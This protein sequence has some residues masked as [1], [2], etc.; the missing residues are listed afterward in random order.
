MRNIYILILMI[1]ASTSWGQPVFQNAMEKPGKDFSAPVQIGSLA[2]GPG[3]T[4]LNYTWNFSNMTFSGNSKF[5]VIDPLMSLYKNN[6]PQASYVYIVDSAYNYFIVT[7]SNLQMVTKNI[8][9]PGGMNDYS[10]NPK[11]VMQFPFSYGLEFTDTCMGTGDTGAHTVVVKY[12]GYGILLMPDATHRNV[13]RASETYATGTDYTWYM[14]DPLIPVL[15]YD[16]TNSLFT[17]IM[18]WPASTANIMDDVSNE[19]YPNPVTD[20]AFFNINTQNGPAE[21]HIYD[22]T[23]KQIKTQEL[24]SSRSSINMHQYPA[25]MYFYTITQQGMIQKGKF[26]KQ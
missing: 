15:H 22:G 12:D 9:T 8:T 3:G 6:Y 26:V 14:E 23:G 16:H 17:Y 21:L 10:A 4:G 25:G 20:Q 5:M 2:S 13:A 11:T 7:D 19:I 1:T 18:A 24:T